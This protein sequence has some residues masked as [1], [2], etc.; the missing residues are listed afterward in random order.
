MRRQ[1]AF[2]LIELLV[3]I[4]IIAILAAIL[5]PVFAQAR[6]KARQSSCLSNVKQI[7]A[8]VMMYTQDYDETLPATGWQGPCTDPVSLAAGDAYFSGLFSFPIASAPYIKN[9]DI[10]KCPSDSEAGGFNKQNS[11]CYEKQLLAVNM[12][13]AYVGMNTEVNKMRD[14]FP[15]SYAANYILSKAYTS[16][17]VPAGTTNPLAMFNL[18]EIRR[19]ANLFYLADVGSNQAANGNNFAGWYITPGYG[20]GTTDVRWRRGKRHADGRNWLFCDGHAK[21]FKDPAWEKTPGVAFTEG[22]LRLQYRARGVYTDPS[23]ETDIP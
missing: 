11:V 13:G 10:F 14:A 12:P 5:F 1:N 9:W 4:A 23:W 3:V 17:L 20:N 21:W 7:G 18:A 2:T 15:L 8:A 16:V 19:P 22:E 6:E